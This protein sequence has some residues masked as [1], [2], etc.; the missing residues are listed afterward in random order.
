MKEVY[1]LI[2]RFQKISEKTG[3]SKMSSFYVELYFSSRFSEDD[4]AT[5]S[6]GGYDIGGWPRHRT[7][8]STGKTLID[9][10]RKIVEEAEQETANDGWCDNCGDYTTFDPDTGKCLGWGCEE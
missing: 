6:V 9:D 10:L 5:I 4:K 1:D 8:D 7:V 2:H 3:R